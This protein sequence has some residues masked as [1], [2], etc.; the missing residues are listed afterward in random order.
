MHTMIKLLSIYIQYIILT[1]ETN[2]I[3]T[4]FSSS[5]IVPLFCF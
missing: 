5:L 4:S 1:L 2:V 3:M